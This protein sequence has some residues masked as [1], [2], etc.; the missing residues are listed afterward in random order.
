M[1]PGDRASDSGCDINPPSPGNTPVQSEERKATPLKSETDKEP[2]MLS[3]G[4]V[5]ASI[6]LNCPKWREIYVLDER[7]VPC[8]NYLWKYYKL[9]KYD[10]NATITRVLQLIAATVNEKERICIYPPYRL[11]VER[12]LDGLVEVVEQLVKESDDCTD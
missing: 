12:V 1:N 3:F 9:H 4:R 11:V 5:E 7:K 6:L 10:K 8:A 2:P